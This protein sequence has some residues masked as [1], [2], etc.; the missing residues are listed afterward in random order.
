MNE[1]LHQLSSLEET[2]ERIQQ[3]I[4]EKDSPVW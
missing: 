1:K 4:K 2:K 3:L